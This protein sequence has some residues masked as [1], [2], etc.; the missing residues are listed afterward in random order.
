MPS[1]F[2]WGFLSNDVVGTLNRPDP[3]PSTA[4]VRARFRVQFYLFSGKLLIGFNQDLRV[5]SCHLH[6]E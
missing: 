1:L 3:L 4:A 6:R 5:T 2:L